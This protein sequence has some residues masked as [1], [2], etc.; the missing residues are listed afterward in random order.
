MSQFR[1]LFVDLG[2]APVFW[3]LTGVLTTCEYFLC[4]V[5][6][7]L[8]RSKMLISQHNSCFTGFAS[9]VRYLERRPNPCLFLVF[10]SELTKRGQAGTHNGRETSSRA[11]ENQGPSTGATPSHLWWL[12]LT[13]KSA[14]SGQIF[15][16]F[17]ETRKLSLGVGGEGRN[18]WFCNVSNKFIFLNTVQALVV[19]VSS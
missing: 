4:N 18:S 17:I 14:H 6:R 2:N 16:F 13:W 7:L 19:G 5:V 1:E 10:F 8:W 15:Q 11:G 9:Q 3:W 12:L